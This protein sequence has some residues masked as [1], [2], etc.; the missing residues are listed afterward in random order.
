L[1]TKLGIPYKPHWPSVSLWT[2][3]TTGSPPLI[4]PGL[5]HVPLHWA[6]VSSM[7]ESVRA[8][9]EG[10]RYS[11]SIRLIPDLDGA[12]TQARGTAIPPPVVADRISTGFAS[13]SSTKTCNRPRA[14]QSRRSHLAILPLGVL[15]CFD[16][17]RLPPAIQNHLDHLWPEPTMPLIGSRCNQVNPLDRGVISLVICPCN[18]AR[19]EPTV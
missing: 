18:L 14:V 1:V 8:S 7:S 9:P 6:W 5:R 3:P 12:C 10:S 4:Y 2:M 13:T 11:G 16:L 17:Q 15:L 19:M